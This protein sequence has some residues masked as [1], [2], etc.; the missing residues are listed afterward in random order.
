MT[1][2]AL[3]INAALVLALV[4]FFTNAS[5]VFGPKRT[6]DGDKGLPYETGM[7]PM[8]R[9]DRIPA[10]YHRYAVL[11]VI[12]DV[13]LAFLVP[14]GLL[15]DRLTFEMMISMTTF[16]LLVGLTLTTVPKIPP[17]VTTLSF[18]FRCFTICSSSF[19]AYAWGRKTR[20]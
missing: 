18:F 5:A 16:I 1:E 9:L 15:R 12:F 8:S 13:D 19:L 10:T 4:L 17:L 2:I 7:P 3:L 11:F 14:W 20:R 6:M